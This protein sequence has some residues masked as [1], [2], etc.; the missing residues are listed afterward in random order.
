MLNSSPG[1]LSEWE[2]NGE[3]KVVVKIEGA[4]HM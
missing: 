2:R 3:K 4:Q 1:V